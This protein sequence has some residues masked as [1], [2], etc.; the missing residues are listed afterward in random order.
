MGNRYLIV[1]DLHLCDVEDH[2]DGWKAYKN[3]RY[4]FDRERWEETLKISERIAAIEER[5][6]NENPYS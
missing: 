2:S 4:R 5:M 3:S 6:S 1:S